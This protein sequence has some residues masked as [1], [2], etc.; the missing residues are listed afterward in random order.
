VLGLDDP[1]TLNTGAELAVNFA[2]Q[3]QFVK[4]QNVLHEMIQR[5]IQAKD[6]SAMSGAWYEIACAEAV[7]G[8]SDLAIEYLKKSNSISPISAEWMRNDKDLKSLHKD[9][10]F[11]EIIAKAEQSGVAA[12]NTHYLPQLPN[13]VL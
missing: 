4:A 9:P 3:K 10:R 5:A 11:A 7:M 2:Y 1:D 12:N 13:R 8:K 6:Q